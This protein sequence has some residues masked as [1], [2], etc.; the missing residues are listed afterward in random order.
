L[1]IYAGAVGTMV[2][3]LKAGNT[4]NDTLIL[5]FSE[6]GR[7]VAQN[8]GHGTD[9]GAANNVFVI[10]NKLKKPGLFNEAPDL[11][12]LDDIGD[13]KYEIDF[14][15]VYANILEDWLKVSREHIVTPSVRPVTII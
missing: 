5:T 15:S 2:E 1:E 8:A 10:G 9:H 11:R 3:D 7:R 12:N 13:V 6:F 14:R 4:F